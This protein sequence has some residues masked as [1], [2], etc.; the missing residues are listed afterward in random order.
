MQKKKAG[1]MIKNMLQ[2]DIELLEIDTSGCEDV[3]SMST[4]IFLDRKKQAK[5]IDYDNFFLINAFLKFISFII[6]LIIDKSGH[7]DVSPAKSKDLKFSNPKIISE[8]PS[9]FNS[10]FPSRTSILEIVCVSNIL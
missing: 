7:F 5:P 1:Q 2:Y 4:N 6:S 9:K 10:D 3:G 8:R